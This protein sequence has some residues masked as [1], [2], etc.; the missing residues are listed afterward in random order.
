MAYSVLVFSII[1][2]MFYVNTVCTRHSRTNIDNRLAIFFGV[3]IILMAAFRGPKVGAD[4]FA[5]MLDYEN[6]PDYSFEF[7]KERYEGYLGYYYLSKIFTMAGLPLPVWFGFLETVYLYSLYRLICHFKTDS[8]LFSLLIFVTTGLM[9]FSFAGLKQVLAMSMMIF[10]FLAFI[11]KKY[12]IS[13]ALIVYAYTC[14]SVALIF[15]VAFLFY[16]FRDKKYFYFI[17]GTG[18]IISIGASEWALSTMVEILDDEH[19]ESYLEIDNTYTATTLIFYWIIVG[20]SL[21]GYKHY[22]RTDRANARLVLGLS[23]TGCAIQAM[24]AISPN[25]FRM[26]LLFTSFFMILIPK[27]LSESRNNSTYISILRFLEIS[28]LTFYF[29]YTGRDAE[30][31]L[32]I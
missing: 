15:L 14:H 13:T 10:S 3:V 22:E 1:L 6:I 23:L 18:I 7:I 24:A 2:S 17:V 9:M 21:L 5:Y 28:M 31:T 29:L 12:I 16:L 20:V 25:A 19:Y 27:S 4:T 32:I 30:Y 8:K 26:A 11:H